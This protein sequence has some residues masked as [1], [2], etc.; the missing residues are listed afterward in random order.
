MKKAYASAAFWLGILLAGS[1]CS[2]AL[3]PP[4]DI[5]QYGH[6]AWKVRDGFVNGIIDSI[7]Q[8]PDGYLWLGA[9][10]GL[11]RFDGVGR[12][13][14]WQP[15]AGQ[16]LP[17]SL[18]RDLLVSRD[19]TLWIGTQKGLAKWKDGRLTTLPELAGQIVGKVFQDR[20]GTVW[21]S[22]ISPGRI[23]A[24]RSAKVECNG[25]G[26]FG[27]S[28]FRIYE[29][30]KGTLWVSGETAVWRWAPGPPRQYALPPGV[31]YTNALIEDDA[32]ELLIGTPNGLYQLSDGRIRKYALAGIAGDI[33]ASPFFR[34]KDGRL[35]IGTDNQGVLQLRDGRIEKFS[36]IEGLTDDGV[37][38]IFEDREGT[39]WVSTLGG[40]DRFRVPAVSTISRDEGLLNATV[41]SVEATADGSVWIG[42]RLGLSR[43]QSGRIATYRSVSSLKGNRDPHPSAAQ[44]SAAEIA[45]SGLRGGISAQG[46]DD[47]GRLWVGTAEAVY[48]F[49]KGRFVSAYDALGGNVASI[50]GDGRGNVWILN[51]NVGFFKW[52][53]EGVVEKISWPGRPGYFWAA[54]L[55]DLPKDGLWL[56]FL[57][58]A[59]G[60]A[61]LKDG[62]V[63]TTYTAANGLG[64]GRVTHLRFGS[65]G[66][67]WAATQGGLSRIKDGHIATLTSANGLPCE[68]VHWSIEDDDHSVW[69]YMPCGLVRI[70][71]SELD[72][73]VSD[74]R[75]VLKTTLFDSSDGV[76]SRPIV[77]GTSP[78]VT[79][80]SDGRI[81]FATFDGVS[82]VD[83]H[84]L[85]FNKLP[86]PVH[87][88]KITADDKP[89]DLSSG[90]K[91]PAQVRNLDID[92]TALSLVVPEKV[93]FRIKLEGQDKDWRELVNVRHVEYTNL[94]PRH[95][96]FRVLA[97]N[98][99]GVWNEIGDS[100]DFT[101]PP[102]WYQTN[103]FRAACVAAF[104]LFIWAVYQ[105]RVQQMQEQERK[106]REAVE[107][108]PALAFVADPRGDRPFVNRGW[109]EYTGLSAEQASGS[110]WEKAIH[111]DDLKR[112][113]ERW[114]TAQS[115]GQPLDYES[116]L[117]RGSDGVYRWFQTRAR[118]LRDSR[119]KVV[120]WC[121]VAT[122]I[123]D[124][125]RAEQL[126]A[127]LAHVGR[128]STM[129]EL[130]A[131]ISHELNQ[132][133]TAS[134]LNASLQ[135][136]FLERNPPDLSEVRERAAT[137]I[138]MGTMA[139]EII[140]RLRSLYK[141]ETPK[142]GPLGVNEVIIEMVE[143]LRGQA[144]RHAVS[145]RTD[146]SN[147]LPNVIADRVQVQ[148][149]LMNLMLNAIEA[150]SDTGGVLTV[151]SQLRQDREIEISVNDTGPGLPVGKADQIFD[152]FF[153]TKPQ[154]S[155]MGLA[156]SKT[157]VESHGGQ[158]WA[159]GNGGSGAT[160]HFTLP[161]AS[162]ETDTPST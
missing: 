76:R 40:L 21:I 105:F 47:R 38:S 10:S 101:I 140:D 13:V 145:L 30:R 83:P 72:A 115:T 124:R 57:D 118:P 135:I 16:Q 147:D 120:K 43:W 153:T 127:D 139:S 110:G 39:I 122:D 93:R 157:I 42:T 27:N 55:L 144:T 73:W 152:A 98:N 37:V 75:Y 69:L 33:R 99:S 44:S 78:A 88:E 31:R 23:C 2:R 130:A 81:W 160:F 137:I 59:G 154:G 17:S 123:E 92:Y 6:T 162:P 103:L 51:G 65:R 89:F 60:L 129:G 54:L 143:L 28:A 161:V 148:Q 19:G 80:S 97:C 106:F 155:G 49:D 56:G 12:P 9:D 74:P 117:R 131:S 109:L 5:S 141:K 90:M 87:I 138:E 116:R 77:G 32:G 126:Q 8:T 62:R 136:E 108:M 79:K 36:A 26:S 58:E 102:A 151:R 132:P 15:P 158:I 134:I 48:Y 34:S 149:V 4:L 35:W 121:A 107:T 133:I 111:P 156:I 45:N 3:D 64:K 95:Y 24:V 159:N 94:P 14:P 61:Y 100:L 53:P 7:A 85:A 20:L 66:A 91:L 70:A 41:A 11:F 52:K 22:L 104:F 114:R 112:V 84:H 71:R 67:L 113:L 150:M 1:S 119:G 25:S 50:S 82:V 128:V 63:L 46:L 18:I 29:D 68:T 142:R 146:L 86:P 125:K 96:K